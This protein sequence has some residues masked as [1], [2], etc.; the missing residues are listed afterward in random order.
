MADVARTSSPNHLSPAN[1]EFTA[2]LL[3]KLS[4]LPPLSEEGRCHVGACS[5]NEQLL[6][7]QRQAE[8]MSLTAPHYDLAEISRRLAHLQVCHRAARDA[9]PLLAYAQV[10]ITRAIGRSGFHRSFVPLCYGVCQIE[11]LQ[12]QQLKDMALAASNL[13]RSD[14]G[15]SVLMPRS[16]S[17]STLPQHR[18]SPQ[19]SPAPLSSFPVRRGP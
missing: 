17:L 16:V 12:I 14:L 8:G 18:S 1:Q 7:P 9:R 19:R 3:P 2:E 5:K 10:A 15:N 13:S 4:A 6:L 11:R